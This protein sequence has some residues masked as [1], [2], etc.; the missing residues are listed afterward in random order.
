MMVHGYERGFHTLGRQTLMAPIRWTRDGWPVL[1]RGYK[2]ERALCVPRGR[3]AKHTMSLS[4]PPELRESLRYE[5]IRDDL[6]AAGGGIRELD[7]AR[8]DLRQRC[9]LSARDGQS[10]RS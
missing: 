6:C 8:Y 2:P 1:P 10:G 9:G 4:D 5:L 7:R 3:S